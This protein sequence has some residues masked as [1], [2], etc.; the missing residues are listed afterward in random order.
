MKNKNNKIAELER[1]IK[2]LRSLLG[3]HERRYVVVC[4][5]LGAGIIFMLYNPDSCFLETMIAL[6]LPRATILV[7]EVQRRLQRI[8]KGMCFH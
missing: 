2:R 5:M 8:G 3:S 4:L 6:G 1:E 7:G